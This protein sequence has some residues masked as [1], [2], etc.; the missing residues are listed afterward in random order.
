MR[1]QRYEEV[2]AAIDR[3][4]REMAHLRREN[5]Q[6]RQKTAELLEELE[7]VKKSSLADG[8]RTEVLRQEREALLARVKKIRE[9]ISVLEE[10]M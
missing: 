8:Q 10:P 2:T 7:E 6:L 3:V 1:E 4:A 5:A 9:H